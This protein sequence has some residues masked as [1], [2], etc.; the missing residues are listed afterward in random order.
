MMVVSLFSHFPISFHNP[1]YSIPLSHVLNPQADTF[2]P[3]MAASS[4]K[5]NCLG[6]SIIFKS[7]IRRLPLLIVLLHKIDPSTK[8]SRTVVELLFKV[9]VPVVSVHQRCFTHT[10]LETFACTIYVRSGSSTAAFHRSY[11]LKQ[12]SEKD[13]WG[14]IIVH[15]H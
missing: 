2:S 10:S 15:W 4:F 1:H 6:S 7:F 11:T 8:L 9:S 3:S 5:S 14:E 13:Q 12:T